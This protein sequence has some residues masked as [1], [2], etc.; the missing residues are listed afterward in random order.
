MQ[1]KFLEEHQYH[2]EFSKKNRQPKK[3]DRVNE[4]KQLVKKAS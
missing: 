2:T 1:I 4:L 3:E